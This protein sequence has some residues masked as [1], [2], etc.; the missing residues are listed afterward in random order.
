M[1]IIK[2]Y[3]N[4]DPSKPEQLDGLDK[5][6]AGTS[7]VFEATIEP[8]A[9]GIAVLFEVTHGAR[10]VT[11]A[12]EITKKVK[13]TTDDGKARLD[14]VLTSHG[15]DEFTVKAS[16]SEGDN[17]GQQI[18]E[19]TYIVWRR[20]YYQMSRFKAGTPGAGQAAD[21]MSEVPAYDITAV[22]GELAAREHNIELVD[23]TTKALIDRYANVLT[24]ED[25]D[26]D[27]KKSG[28][29]GYDDSLAP[30]VL[31]VVLVNQIADP[32]E[33]VITRSDLENTASVEVE[34]PDDL[35]ND[36]TYARE[37]D[38]LIEGT[39]R[40]HDE[41][42]WL[43]ID[44]K[45]ITRT[46]TDEATIKVTGSDHWRKEADEDRAID[47]RIRFRYDPGG[48]EGISFYN[49]IWLATSIMNDGPIS[50]GSIDKTV[51]HEIGHFIG[52]VPVDQSTF[53]DEKGH[54]G[55]HCSTGLSE[56]ELDLDDYG[57]LEGTCT[58]F[59]EGSD[60]QVM[61]FCAVCDPSVR[62]CSV[63]HRTMPK[64]LNRW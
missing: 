37:E 27:Y 11:R 42:D 43:P 3:V 57:D 46:A 41:S 35:W 24:D 14:Y 4:L 8:K 60:S 51:V 15:G 36:P 13:T 58:M 1:A 54:D 62:K 19:D 30:V 23:K 44:P 40:F 33:S 63:Q 61:E 10:N 22:K 21:S 53:Y 18:G 29:D 28:L 12:S 2:Q 6:R 64:D 49:G 34:F 9:T 38:W 5:A 52:M 17:K 26:R 48:S 39:W 55:E 45:L 31:R 47:V 7:V 59:G 32:A 25:D 50:A 20:L 56:D 16:L